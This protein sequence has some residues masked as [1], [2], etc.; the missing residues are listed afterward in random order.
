M[1]FGTFSGEDPLPGLLNI[2]PVAFQFCRN[3]AAGIKIDQNEKAVIF[4]KTALYH[5]LITLPGRTRT[6]DLMVRSH[7]LYPT[8]LRADKISSYPNIE[9]V[10]IDLSI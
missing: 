3:F 5:A 2:N 4:S 7:A 10:N 9:V 1:E 8:G 6:S